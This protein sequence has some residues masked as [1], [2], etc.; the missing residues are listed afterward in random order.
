MGVSWEEGAFNLK[1]DF[2]Y[3]SR[4]KREVVK[5]KVLE[6]LHIYLHSQH[7]GDGGRGIPSLRPAESILKRGD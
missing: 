6:G 5:G 1:L 3:R 4:Q 2:I 7:S